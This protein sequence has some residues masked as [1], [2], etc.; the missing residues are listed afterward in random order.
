MAYH[1]L[2][3]HYTRREQY[4]YATTMLHGIGYDMACMAHHVTLLAG[5]RYREARDASYAFEITAGFDLTPY[6]RHVIG[7]I[8]FDARAALVKLSRAVLAII[9]PRHVRVWED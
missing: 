4:Q 6:R 9:A 7:A 8:A 3:E 1:A 2:T 5:R